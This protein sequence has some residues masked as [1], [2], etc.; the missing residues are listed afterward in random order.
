MFKMFRVVVV[1]LSATTIL[2]DQGVYEIPVGPFKGLYVELEQPLLF[3]RVGGPD[4]EGDFFYLYHEDSVW[5][6]G[7]GKNPTNKTEN[8]KA[9]KGDGDPLGRTNITSWESKKTNK[10]EDL[11]SCAECGRS[12]N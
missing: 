6:L 9:P 11:C 8:Y 3:Q 12:G 2:A 5:K 4:P 7:T 10:P 1:V